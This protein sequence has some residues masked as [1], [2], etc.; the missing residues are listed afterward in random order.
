MTIQGKNLIALVTA[1]TLAQ[2]EVTGVEA[3]LPDADQVLAGVVF[4]AVG[5]LQVGTYTGPDLTA[6]G[7]ADRAAAVEQLEIYGEPVVYHPAGGTPRAVV[8]I[9]TRSGPAELMGLPPGA[10]AEVLMVTVLDDPDEGIALSE[11]DT[12]GDF[13]SVAAR[14]SDTPRKRRLIRVAHQDTAMLT[15]EVQ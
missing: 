9:V 1:G 10:R 14:R 7:E 6:G 13:V 15:L 4:G 3:V 8:A 11:L 5:S 12:G 2:A